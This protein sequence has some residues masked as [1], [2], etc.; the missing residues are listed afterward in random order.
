MVL[1]HIKVDIDCTPDLI[2][3]E[4]IECIAQHNRPI[5][6]PNLPAKRASKPIEYCLSV[7]LERGQDDWGISEPPE[8]IAF[9]SWQ[10]ILKEPVFPSAPQCSQSSYVL[11]NI[12]QP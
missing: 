2:G 5:S 8:I 4:V 1:M 6:L 12:S 11:P 10:P 9:R 3:V 7:K